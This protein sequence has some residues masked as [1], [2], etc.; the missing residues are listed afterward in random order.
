VAPAPGQVW[1]YLYR[2]SAGPLAS[3]GTYGT[4]SGSRERI[5]AGGGCG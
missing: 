4:G 5:P 2:G 1:F 3:P